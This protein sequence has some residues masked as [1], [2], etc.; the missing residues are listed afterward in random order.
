MTEI[1]YDA[2]G[3]GGH[4]NQGRS[5]F[6][7]SQSINPKGYPRS[8]TMKDEAPINPGFGFHLF[9]DTV[10]VK[11]TSDNM[12]R[13]VTPTSSSHKGVDYRIHDC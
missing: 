2:L 6:Q 9:E 8:F 13:P 12:M 5:T 10:N 11:K 4:T 7:V 1:L 3:R